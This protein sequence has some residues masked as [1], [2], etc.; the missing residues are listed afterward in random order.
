MNRKSILTNFLNVKI[1]SCYFHLKQNVKRW[2]GEHQ[3]SKEDQK[4]IQKTVEILHKAPSRMEFDKRIVEEKKKVVKL[5]SLFWEYFFSNYLAQ[6]GRFPPDIWASF[7]HPGNINHTN[8]VVESKNRNIKLRIGTGLSDTKFVVLSKD[9]SRNQ[10]TIAA[11][12]RNRPWNAIVSNAN[13]NNNKISIEDSESDESEGEEN[14][15]VTNPGVGSRIE[16]LFP[17]I[18][19]WFRGSVVSTS[20]VDYDD[21]DQR[22]VDDWKEI[23]W[24]YATNLKKR[25]TGLKN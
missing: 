2:L 14:E 25:K 11:A 4:E 21:G 15:G 1:C 19:L 3:I 16:V 5:C 12:E 18:N 10:A 24:R 9:Y 23:T 13:N 20:F 8:N 7:S 6:G 22:E 17:D